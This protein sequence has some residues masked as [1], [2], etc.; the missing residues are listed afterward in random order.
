[1][2]RELNSIAHSWSVKPLRIVRDETD[3]CQTGLGRD[4]G[5]L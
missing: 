2:G 4:F 3:R 5:L 1:M